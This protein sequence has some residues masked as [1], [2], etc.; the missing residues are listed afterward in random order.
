MINEPTVFEDVWAEQR[1]RWRLH[2]QC[3]ARSYKLPSLNLRNQY[4]TKAGKLGTISI[5]HQKVRIV[6]KRDQTAI[7]VFVRSRQGRV[8]DG[9]LDYT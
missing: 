1:A 9:L 3:V 4:R 7:F 5:D 2:H 8:R 6:F